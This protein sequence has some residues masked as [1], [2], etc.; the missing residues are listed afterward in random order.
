MSSLRVLG[1]PLIA[2]WSRHCCIVMALERLLDSRWLGHIPHPVTDRTI[3]A[4]ST[5]V[6]TMRFMVSP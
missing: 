1:F 5:E 4:V 6:K 2:M 3:E